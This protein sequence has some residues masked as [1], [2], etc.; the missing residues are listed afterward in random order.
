MPSDLAANDPSVFLK[1]T[2]RKMPPGRKTQSGGGRQQGGGGGV[3]GG[4][5]RGVGNRPLLCA[6][7]CRFK[8]HRVERDQRITSATMTTALLS[9]SEG[10]RIWQN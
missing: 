7:S 5:G 8:S 4:G 10:I 2:N 6:G 9:K 1:E 3:G